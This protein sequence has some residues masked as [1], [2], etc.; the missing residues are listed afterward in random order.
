MTVAELLEELEE[1]GLSLPVQARPLLAPFQDADGAV[2]YMEL[3]EKFG[4]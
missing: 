1:Y 2:R 4:G 3:L